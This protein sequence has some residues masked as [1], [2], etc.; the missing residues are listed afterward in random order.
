[1]QLSS[2]DLNLLL[3]L[4]ALLETG[5]VKDAARRL[6]LSPSATSHALAR[7]RDV[8]GDPVLVRAGR[9]MV[10]TTRAE[11]LAPRVR[12]LLEE[13]EAVFRRAEG[14]DPALLRRSFTAIT[15]DYGELMVVCPTSALL[16][17]EAPGVDLYSRGAGL[18][19]GVTGLR[20][21]IGDVMIGVL[22]SPPPDIATQRLFRDEFVSLLRAGHPALEQRWTKR[23]FAALEHVLVAPGGTPRGTVDTLLAEHGLERRVARTVSTFHAAP[24]LLAQ[25]DYVLTVSRR[26]AERLAGDLGL[27]QRKPPVA[28]EG[29]WIVLA[30]HRRHDEDPEHRYLRVKIAEAVADA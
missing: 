11:A 2:I 1:M 10:P 24:H 28:P 4:D 8:L 19:R 25:T 7:L 26:V 21:G 22:S 6:A 14:F 3:V 5:S 18:D 12:R 20:E 23:R 9:R 17:R 13:A 15:N 30:W 16:A 27:V 29:Y